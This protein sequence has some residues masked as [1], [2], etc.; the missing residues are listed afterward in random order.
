MGK[1]KYWPKRR[2]G[3]GEGGAVLHQG[4]HLQAAVSV[5]LAWVLHAALPPIYMSWLALWA[6]AEHSM[7][8]HLPYIMHVMRG[9]PFT[10]VPIMV[11]ALPFDR[12]VAPLP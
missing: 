2:G 12:W 4:G 1:V 6:Q 5:P 8:L 3:F 11:G 9:H 7:E 10:L